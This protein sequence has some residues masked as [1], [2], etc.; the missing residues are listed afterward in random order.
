[1]RAQASTGTIYYNTYHGHGSAE[2]TRKQSHDT[3][4]TNFS[5]HSPSLT[6][7]SLH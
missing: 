5:R 2:L 7:T 3:T 4:E 6:H 1:M